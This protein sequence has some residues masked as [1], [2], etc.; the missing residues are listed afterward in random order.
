M[1]TPSKPRR[2]VRRS[3]VLLLTVATLAAASLVAPRPAGAAE[4]SVSGW[5]LAADG[6]VA[7]FGGAPHHGQTNRAATA[8]SLT[9]NAAGDG[10]WILWNDGVV[11]ATSATKIPPAGPTAMPRG[12]E[13]SGTPASCE[14]L[15]PPGKRTRPTVDKRE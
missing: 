11:S 13:R 3:L 4:T 15:V 7:A 1:T 12:L 8:V 14:K 2:R 9:A 5:V 10:Y 6:T